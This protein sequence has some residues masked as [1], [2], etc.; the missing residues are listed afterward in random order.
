MRYLYVIHLSLQAMGSKVRTDIKKIE[1][2][3]QEHKKQPKLNQIKNLAFN[4]MF[5]IDE[6]KNINWISKKVWPQTVDILTAYI[7]CHQ[8]WFYMDCSSILYRHGMITT[9]GKQ[10]NKMI[11]QDETGSSSNLGIFV[12]CIF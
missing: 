8:R 2:Q 10:A 3:I 6:K 7:R 11:I 5:D 12:Y 1:Q 4:T 9:S